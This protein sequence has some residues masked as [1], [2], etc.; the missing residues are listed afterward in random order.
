MAFEHLASYETKC[1]AA[2]MG[3]SPL[4]P[5]AKLHLLPTCNINSA[6]FGDYAAELIRLETIVKNSK[7]GKMTEDQKRESYSRLRKLLIEHGI[8]AG[9]DNVFDGQGEEIPYNQENMEDLIWKLP[10]NLL[11]KITAFTGNEDNY[12]MNAFSRRG[13]KVIAEK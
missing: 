8:I 4:G 13:E 3:F 5:D 11:N 1:Q 6:Y 9:W 7:D 12:T 10:D 2:V